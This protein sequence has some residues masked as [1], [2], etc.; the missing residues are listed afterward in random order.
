MASAHS[1]WQRMAD[2]AL[3]AGLLSIAAP[4]GYWITMTQ[5]VRMPGNVL[6]DMTA[7]PWL[8]SALWIATGSLI[9]PVMEQ[10]GFWGYGQVMLQECFSPATAIVIVSIL[11]AFG[12]HPPIGAALWPKLVFYFLAS[13][14]FGAMA[15]FTNSILPS[16]VIHIAGDLIFFTAIWPHDTGRPL[17]AVSGADVWF[18]IHVAQPGG[19]TFLAVRAFGQL[20]KVAG[21]VPPAPIRISERCAN[22]E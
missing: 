12:P 11:F 9:G 17:V 10:A 20:A 3:L 22:G 18:W 14:T 13:A 8:T 1:L 4:A 6:P 7:Y 16:L 2:W 15:F 5:F 19:F 21:R